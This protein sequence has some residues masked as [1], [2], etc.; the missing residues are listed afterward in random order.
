MGEQS[1]LLNCPFCGGPVT[2]ESAPGSYSEVYGKRKWWGV[3]CR[4]TTNIGG[5]CAVQISP[6]ASKEAAI[7][8]WNTRAS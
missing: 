2:L 4:N 3:V 5:T 8:R 7:A 6:S 1:K